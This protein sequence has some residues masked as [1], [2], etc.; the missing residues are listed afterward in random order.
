MTKPKQAKPDLDLTAVRDGAH[1]TVTGDVS[2]V[3]VRLNAA[4]APVADF[5]LT[6]GKQE[7]PVLLSQ[8]LVDQLGE[9]PTD[10][11]RATVAGR[12]DQREGTPAIWASDVL[13]APRRKASP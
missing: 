10:G 6:V 4:D 7:V 3:T 8:Y 12:V 9:L 1:V 5:V 11:D 13:R 2:R